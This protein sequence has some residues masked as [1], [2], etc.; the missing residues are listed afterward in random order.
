[1]VRFANE[2]DSAGFTELTDIVTCDAERLAQLAPALQTLAGPAKA[3]PAGQPGGSMCPS[4]AT[5]QQRLQ[6]QQVEGVVVEA[7]FLGSP[8]VIRCINPKYTVQQATNMVKQACARIMT[9]MGANEDIS[10]V[11]SYLLA[12]DVRHS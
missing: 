7:L 5:V 3:R 4:Y 1:M 9:A 12:P 2:M 6:G 8:N 10:G 11:I